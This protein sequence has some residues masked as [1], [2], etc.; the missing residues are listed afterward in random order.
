MGKQVKK[1]GVETGRLV[2]PQTTTPP[3]ARP[4]HAESA[5]VLSP[6]G[7]DLSSP[8]LGCWWSAEATQF[9]AAGEV[10]E[11]GWEHAAAPIWCER[12]CS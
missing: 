12:P 4:S 8:A 6:I 3:A 7:P 5:R 1:R 10:G 9:V 11:R 2:A